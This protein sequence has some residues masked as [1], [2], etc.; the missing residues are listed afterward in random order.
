MYIRYN[1]TA[2]EES[3]YLNKAVLNWRRKPT[4]E[5]TVDNMLTFFKQA[6]KE[7][8]IKQKK[9]HHEASSVQ[10]LQQKFAA[11]EERVEGTMEQKIDG[12]VDM[13]NDN[14]NDTKII[15]GSVPGTV[16]TNTETNHHATALAAAEA[17]NESLKARNSQLAAGV[18]TANQHNQFGGGDARG[19]RQ[20]RGRGR[21]G[22]GGKNP[23]RN[24]N[25]NATPAIWGPRSIL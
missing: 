19:R 17:R 11:L 15:A 16:I 9:Y 5:R 14:D 8:R 23:G 25:T 3:N 4:T 21:E 2:I 7:E 1:V 6:H 10:A 13:I 24:K 12:L 18:N 22:R 20:G